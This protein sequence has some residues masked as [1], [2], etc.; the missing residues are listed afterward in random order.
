MAFRKATR[1]AI[2][3]QGLTVKPRLGRTFENRLIG[4][5][6]RTHRS[7]AFHRTAQTYRW[8]SAALWNRCRCARAMNG[9]TPNMTRV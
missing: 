5:S 9:S 7:A 1:I 4:L 3:V 6:P 2:R 8:A